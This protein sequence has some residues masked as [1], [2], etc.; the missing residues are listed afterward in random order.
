M[1][2]P[3]PPPKGTR[4][5]EQRWARIAG[6]AGIVAIPITII[7]GVAQCSAGS[8]S[9]PNPTAATSNPAPTSAPS[10]GESQSTVP[11]S[12]LS[13][14]PAE[15]NEPPS[16]SGGSVAV[17]DKVGVWGVYLTDPNWISDPP[18]ADDIV[19]DPDVGISASNNAR[20]AMVANPSYSTCAAANYNIDSQ[21]WAQVP[22]GTTLCIRTKDTRVGRVQVFWKKNQDGQASEIRVIGVIWQPKHP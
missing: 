11:S 10:G 3:H 5:F 16:Y 20:F 17:P 9:S 19:T 21:T 2:A 15:E 14:A 4:T 7:F 12:V 18:S 13:P 22:S 1:S 6:I 8:S